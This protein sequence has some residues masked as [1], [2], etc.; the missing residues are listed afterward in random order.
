MSWNEYH[1]KPPFQCCVSLLVRLWVEISASPSYHNRWPC[2]PPCEAVSWNKLHGTPQ[3]RIWGQP[4]CEAVSWNIG[5]SAG[6]YHVMVSLLVRLW[7]E[8]PLLEYCHP[9]PTVSLLVR[10]WVEIKPYSMLPGPLMS[11]S[12]WGCELKY[13]FHISSRMAN[14]VSLLVRLWVEIGIRQTTT[15]LYRVSLLVR[16]W[17]EMC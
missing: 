9:I 12:L 14:I 3:P 2:Q 10:L 13:I 4:P 15:V 11:A 8:I 16:L 6:P 1:V 17:V 5:I 7:V